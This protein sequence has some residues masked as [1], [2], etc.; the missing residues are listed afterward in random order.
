MRLAAD[1]SCESAGVGVTGV[2]SKA[3]RAAA[4][5][6]ALEGQQL[7]EETIAQLPL[8]QLMALTQTR[9]F[10]PQKT[11]GGIWRR[12]TRNEHFNKAWNK[13]IK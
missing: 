6:A 3:Y 8:T 2:A 4:V 5:E 1:G 13:P 9:T 7:N 12:C 10:T 11:T